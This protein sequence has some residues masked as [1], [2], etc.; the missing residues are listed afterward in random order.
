MQLYRLICFCPEQNLPKGVIHVSQLIF[1]M[2]FLSK[3]EIHV[4]Q[5]LSF[6]C[7]KVKANLLFLSI[8][9]FAL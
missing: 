4:P 3:I 5:L 9:N 7:Q 2:L 8:V 6:D 1:K